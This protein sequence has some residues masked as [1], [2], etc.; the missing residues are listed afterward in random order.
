MSKC[1][2]SSNLFIEPQLGRMKTPIKSTEKMNEAI[3]EHDNKIYSLATEASKLR[4]RLDT[5]S[6]KAPKGELAKIEGTQR[7]QEK[8]E[9][10]IKNLE[11]DKASLSKRLNIVLMELDKITS[12]KSDY[13]KQMGDQLHVSSELEEK[14]TKS[15][16]LSKVLNKNLQDDLKYEK[17]LNDKL[18]E[19]V[20]RYET[21][22][23]QLLVQLREQQG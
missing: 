10:H 14:I 23:S 5:L 20:S 2:L 4:D 22:K 17:E 7:A 18:R 1:S 8:Y 16:N 13:E 3:A 6:G 19:E 21:Q 9:Y 11:N 12:E 15:D